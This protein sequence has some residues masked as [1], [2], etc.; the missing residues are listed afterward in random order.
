VTGSEIAQVNTNV[1]P[2]PSTLLQLASGCLI[3]F[4]LRRRV[5]R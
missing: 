2:E 1:V 4:G 5:R 3:L